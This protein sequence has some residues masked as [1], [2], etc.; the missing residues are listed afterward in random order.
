MATSNA[1]FVKSNKYYYE[2]MVGIKTGYHSKA[3]NCFVGAAL[4]NGVY[5][6][7]VTLHSTKTGCW[8]DTKRLMEYGYPQYKTYS[9]SELWGANPFYVSIENA[10]TDDEGKG[11]LALD[12]VPGGTILNY[13]I[14][15]LPDEYE[16]TLADYKKNMKLTYTS[17]L[18]API[19]KGDII[20]K[21]TMPGKD[22]ELLETT[23]V[24]SRDV[25]QYK[26]LSPIEQL[27]PQ[28]AVFKL[29]PVKLLLALAALILVLLIVLRIY[30]GVRRNR[31]RKQ[32]YR[33]KLEAY[34]KYKAIK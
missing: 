20:G 9:F 2:P 13:S 10:A 33:M 4:K 29:T 34:E 30:V 18:Q 31:K 26:P 14:T 21:L 6:I 16:Q 3:G 1:M 25:Y 8:M 7:S 23:V 19:R 5:L 22:G 12:A 24:A 11:M 27:V 32:L 15:R 17:E 28:L